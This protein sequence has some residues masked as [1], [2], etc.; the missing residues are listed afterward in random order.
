MNKPILSEVNIAND[1]W[2]FSKQVAAMLGMDYKYFSEK[3]IFTTPDFPA[4]FR[5]SAN[6]RRRWLKSEVLGWLNTKRET[7]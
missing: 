4:P 2:V 1:E 6:G 5:F 7:A 3:F